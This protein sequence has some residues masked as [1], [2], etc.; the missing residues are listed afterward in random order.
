MGTEEPQSNPNILQSLH[1]G[2]RE[3]RDQLKWILEFGQ[4]Q[5]QCIAL[6]NICEN[7]EVHEL[8]DGDVAFVYFGR[9]RGVFVARKGPEN[10]PWAVFEFVSHDKTQAF[11]INRLEQIRMRQLPVDENTDPV[12]MKQLVSEMTDF[13]EPPETESFKPS[14]EYL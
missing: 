12:G 13:Y 5:P 11:D 2:L 14:R 7:S 6:S 8:P 4:D 3:L 1:P 9:S 10:S